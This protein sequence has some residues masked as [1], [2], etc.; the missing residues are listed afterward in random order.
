MEIGVVLPQGELHGGARELREFAVAVQEL[1]F[2][3]L[4]AYDHVLGADPDGHP[5]WSGPYDVDNPFHEPLTLFAFLAG[6]CDLELVTGVLVLPQRQT[7]LVAKQ[8]AEVD[9][10]SGG[11]LRL[12]VGLGWNSV[13]YAALGRPMRGLGSRLDEQIALLRALWTQR[14]VTLMGSGEHFDAAGLNPRPARSIPI[15][16][17]GTSDAAYRRAGRLGDGWLPRLSPGPALDAAKAVVALA[18]LSAGRDPSAIGMHGRIRLGA[19]GFDAWRDAG[20]THLAV[21]TLGAG[22][23]SLSEHLR[24]LS[25]LEGEI[26]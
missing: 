15:W 24:A 26:R 21:S 9:L 16:I 23:T 4:L 6:V 14:S 1:G 8:A 11:R 20:A 7:A 22:F 19:G 18:A 2:R 3:H 12:G 5:G 10:L 25:Q 13:E 17:G